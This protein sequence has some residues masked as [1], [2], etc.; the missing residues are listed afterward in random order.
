MWYLSVKKNSM[1]DKYDWYL[2]DIRFPMVPQ[3]TK[4]AASFPSICAALAC[5]AKERKWQFFIRQGSVY[6]RLPKWFWVSDISLWGGVFEIVRVSPRDNW[7]LEATLEVLQHT[8]HVFLCGAA[9]RWTSQLN[10]CTLHYFLVYK[11]VTFWHEFLSII[12]NY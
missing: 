5:R 8:E 2:L 4:S 6:N 9:H 11:F 1:I 3:G 12:Y 10:Q 7:V